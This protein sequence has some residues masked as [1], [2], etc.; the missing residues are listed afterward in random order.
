MKITKY[1]FPIEK[2]FELSDMGK[3]ANFLTIE[4]KEDSDRPCLWCIE[5]P[6]DQRIPMNKRF[7]KRRFSV[8]KHFEEIFD[9]KKYI[10][11]FK[12]K[13][14]IMYHLFEV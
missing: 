11:S 10:G 6:P 12:F 5:N 13:D 1:Y 2:Y 3:Q 14:G 9:Y 8:L 7:T 4:I